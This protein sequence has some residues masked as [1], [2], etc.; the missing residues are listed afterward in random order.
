MDTVG[1]Q[2]L[3][4]SPQEDIFKQAMQ[5]L[6]Q[7]SNLHVS[8]AEWIP[9]IY[10]Y[11]IMFFYVEDP[12][13]TYRT[14]FKQTSTVKWFDKSIVLVT[15]TDRMEESISLLNFPAIK[16]VV[17]VTYL[18]ANMSTIMKELEN[19]SFILDSGLYSQVSTFLM[20][21]YKRR[22]PISRFELDYTRVPVRMSQS[23]RDILQLLLDGKDTT[24]IAKMLY[25]N[26]TTV[27]SYISKLIKRCEA[28]DRT[29]LVVSLIRKGWVNSVK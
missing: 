9:D 20:K 17:S 10:Q 15:N 24:T 18:E 21:Q 28:K 14:H 4:H 5:Q 29:D 12:I 19:G 8:N 13:T 25:L 11:D 3:F 22:E 6:P 23:E 16:G 7:L 1:K 27:N 26:T 2:I